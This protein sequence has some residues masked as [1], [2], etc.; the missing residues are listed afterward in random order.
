MA[1]TIGKAFKIAPKDVKSYGY[2]HAGKTGQHRRN[3]GVTAI[4][5]INGRGSYE[6]SRNRTSTRSELEHLPRRER[7]ARARQLTGADRAAFA[8]HVRAANT[9]PGASMR[10]NSS[11]IAAARRNIRGALKGRLAANKRRAPKRL[12]ANTWPGEIRRHADAAHL[13][14]HQPGYA[15]TLGTV[16][17]RKK[18]TKAKTKAKSASRPKRKKTMKSNARRGRTRSKARRA[19]ALKPNRRKARKS[20]RR[21]ATP[22]RRKVSK[23]LRRNSTAKRRV[24][25]T[26]RRNSSAKQRAAA[27]RNLRKARAA[28]KGLKPNRRKSHRRNAKKRR[29]TRK[30]RR[31]GLIS[32]RRKSN[33]RKTHRRNASKRRVS[34]KAHRRNG[35]I[36]NRRR[37]HSRKALRRN[38]SKRRVSRKHR[39]N[40]R[41]FA[42]R[43]NGFLDTMKTVLEIGALTTAGFV[44]HKL[45]TKLVTEQL[46]DR[47]L[48]AAPAAAPATS[49]LVDMVRPFRSVLG[50]A[51]VAA[52]GIMVVNKFVPDARVKMFLTA[53]MAT[54]LVQSVAVVILNKVAPQYA[55][56]L[57]GHDGTAASISA[58]YGLGAGASIMPEYQPI[59]E[60][61]A[62]NGLGEY[63]AQNGLGAYTGNPD[64]MQAA[65]GYGTIDN[66]NSNIVD[67]GGDLDAQL[68]IAEAAAGVGSVPYQATAGYGRVQPF[69]AAAGIGEYFA[70]NGLGAVV[71][72]PPSADT[73]IPGTSDGQLWAG[74]RA[75][76]QPQSRDEMV[77]AGVL[78]TRGN[79]G[80]FG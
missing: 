36:S 35:L 17:K 56:V 13:G 68:S 59:G 20:L 58:M 34:R 3:G 74:T 2:V 9:T 61:L 29:V 12:R 28:R 5:A 25:K 14:H 21:N 47:I 39:S 77:T 79:Q 75:I 31:N 52:G 1:R 70:Q 19:S 66:P 33:K 6:R 48:G 24:R 76:S 63:F 30:H 22:K 43:R 27:L 60:Y 78:E 15:S 50:G 71:S 45:V 53:G 23:T 44:G 57:S 49:G 54:S 16:A 42:F 8:R 69:E 72:V 80:V 18:K 10:T 55:G 46:I 4:A 40:G 38:A 32:N 67:P 64:M 37:K 62:Q 41:R 51:A 73:W 11:K 7:V 26:H 65:A